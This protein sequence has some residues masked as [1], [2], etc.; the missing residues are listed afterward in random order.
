MSKTDNLL[1]PNSDVADMTNTN[2]EGTSIT[3]SIMKLLKQIQMK[4]MKRKILLLLRI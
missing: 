4:L 2:I 3:L 1:S